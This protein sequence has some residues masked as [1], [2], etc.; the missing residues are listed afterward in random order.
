MSR[1]GFGLDV[2]GRLLSKEAV[3]R[4]PM[5]DIRIGIRGWVSFHGQYG[6][7][8]GVGRLRGGPGHN[9]IPPHQDGQRQQSQGCTRGD[10]S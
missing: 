5:D 7:H 8:G 10:W 1:L 9:T 4:G 6:N 3:S 2:Q